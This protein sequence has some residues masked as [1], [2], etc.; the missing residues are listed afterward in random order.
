SANALRFRLVSRLT[1]IADLISFLSPRS[2][3]SA[4][5][6]TRVAA[7]N[8]LKTF[9]ELDGVQLRKGDG[10]YFST[11]TYSSS[12]RHNSWFAGK[13]QVI[14][15]PAGGQVIQL[16]DQSLMF[17]GIQEALLNYCIT[18]SF[19][20]ILS[21]KFDSGTVHKRILCTV[22]L[23]RFK[24]EFSVAEKESIH[25]RKSGGYVQF[26]LEGNMHYSSGGMVFGILPLPEVR[27]DMRAN[28]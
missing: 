4:A 11:E 24:S 2:L 12:G 5:L 22:P 26:E 6:R 7:L 14:D 21:Y 25:I 17:V 1:A 3:L 9:D 15:G 20:T 10:G 28:P 13:S 16:D 19:E 23:G 27:A 8:A 18:Q